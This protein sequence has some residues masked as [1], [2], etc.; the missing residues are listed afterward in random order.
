M[1]NSNNEQLQYSPLGVG[2]FKNKVCLITGAASGIGK[3]TAL[4][5]ANEKASVV[6]ADINEDAVKEVASFIQSNDGNA[7][8]LTVD[9]SKRADV[10]NMIA[11]TSETFG[12]LD[13]AVNC[14]GIAGRH[15]LNVHE[16]PEED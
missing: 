14:A 7:I 5:F 13:C 16:Y 15:S 9:I 11:K 10:K 8:A 2:G 3:A 6:I 4:A 12:R 1:K